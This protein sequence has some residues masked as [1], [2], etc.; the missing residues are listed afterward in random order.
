MTRTDGTLATLPRLALVALALGGFVLA[1]VDPFTLV[2]FGSYVVVG[3]ILAFRRPTN[4]V[5][6]LLIAI[7]FA[8]LGTTTPPRIDFAAL[9]AGRAPLLDSVQ[10]WIAAWIAPAAFLGFAGLAFVFPSG[11]LPAGRWRRPSILVLVIGLVVVALSAVQPIIT[12]SPSGG[13]SIDVPNPIGVLAGAPFWPIFLPASYVYIIAALAIAVLSLLARYG[14]AD[15]QTRLQLRWLLAA[16]AFVLVGIVFGLG[17][18]V[19]R[20]DDAGGLA[21]IPVAIAYPCVPL[22]IG[23]AVLRYRLY[24]IDRIVNRA[25]VY[26]AVTAILAGVFAAVTGLSQRLFIEVAG[27][28]SDAAVVLTT[29][30][31]VAV[32]APLRK[33]VET[34]VDRYFKYDQREYGPYLDELRHLLELV[35]PSHAAARLAREA[36]THTG[37][38]GVAVIGHGEEVLAT[39]GAWPG[40]PV[41]T[42]AVPAS[43][44]PLMAIRLGPRRDRRPYPARQLRAL[45]DAA[46]VAASVLGTRPTPVALI[47]RGGGADSVEGSP[48]PSEPP[49]VAGPA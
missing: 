9:Q 35:E 39:A 29:L 12:L 30:V 10:A 42:V 38:T 36:L 45:A 1:S 48:E 17:T 34:V 24:E 22:A 47:E 28:S 21:W 3:L 31:V 16:L 2:F 6:W 19:V 15:D 32:Y 11:R 20:G 40:G 46:A 8:F 37:A 27:Q 14:R 49:A 44:A 33:R 4:G 7:A 23:V 41:E 5:S 18:I 13:A 43:G 25:L 26:G